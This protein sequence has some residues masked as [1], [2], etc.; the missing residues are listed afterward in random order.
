MHKLAWLLQEDREKQL[1]AAILETEQQR[2]ELDS[3]LW[4]LEERRKQD[5]H[6]FTQLREV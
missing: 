1:Q 5:L 6:E 4:L 2:R 3:R